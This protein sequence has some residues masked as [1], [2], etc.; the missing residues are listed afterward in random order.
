MTA[1]RFQQVSSCCLAETTVHY[2]ELECVKCG[3]PTTTSY[4]VPVTQIVEM[5]NEIAK[6]REQN[7]M[8]A[9][10]AE[11]IGKTEKILSDFA[12]L[13]EGIKNKP[14]DV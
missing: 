5:D 8:L 1:E 12:N 6:L 9:P 3:K 10:T 2:I 7:E 11:Y 13:L 4:V 14:L